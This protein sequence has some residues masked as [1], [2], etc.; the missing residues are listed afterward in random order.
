MAPDGDSPSL[1]GWEDFL[2]DD[3]DFAEEFTRL[4]NNLD[5]PEADDVFDADTYD[6]YVN[7][8][9]NIQDGRSEHPQFAKVTKRLKD[10]RGN[11]MKTPF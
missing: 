1:A 9:L 3:E 2:A 7:M 8:E 6:H 4:F 5:V 11:P 10:H